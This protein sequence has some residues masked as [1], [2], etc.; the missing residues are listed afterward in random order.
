MMIK[1]SK[2]F[3]NFYNL[4]CDNQEI[5]HLYILILNNNIIVLDFKI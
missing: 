2:I 3:G 4:L 5:F 1:V